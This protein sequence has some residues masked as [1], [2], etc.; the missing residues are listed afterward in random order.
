MARESDKW[1]EVGNIK[2]GMLGVSLF[3]S[4]P[5]RGCVTCTKRENF[6]YA[7]FVTFPEHTI[8]SYYPT[9]LYFMWRVLDYT[10]KSHLLVINIFGIHLHGIRHAWYC[11]TIFEWHTM[12]EASKFEFLSKYWI[13]KSYSTW[14]SIPSVKYN[15]EK[16]YCGWK[17]LTTKRWCP[18]IYIY[19]YAKLLTY[20]AWRVG[21]LVFRY[22]LLSMPTR[23]IGCR[24][25]IF[26]FFNF[27]WDGSDKGL[28]VGHVNH[29][30]FFTKF[31]LVI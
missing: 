11:M 30:L 1:K 2:M 15:I 25:L 16:S 28:K 23:T 18:Y 13:S 29:A 12:H 10:C 9:D 27:F 19:I 4:L 3:P 14:I 24:F 8:V 6:P 21:N 7:L 31:K 22:Y 20:E 5:G 26:N 17:Q